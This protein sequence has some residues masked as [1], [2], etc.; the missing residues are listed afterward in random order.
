MT[1][2]TA[3]VELLPIMLKLN[4]PHQPRA[5]DSFCCTDRI[6]CLDVPVSLWTAPVQPEKK[7]VLQCYPLYPFPDSAL[8]KEEIPWTS[9][10]KNL[11]SQPGMADVL[12]GASVAV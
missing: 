6:S 12:R 3:I 9:E 4:S 7:I 2:D 10:V 1:T 5:P 11:L 8:W